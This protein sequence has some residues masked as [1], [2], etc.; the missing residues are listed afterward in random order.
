MNLNIEFQNGRWLVNNK[1]LAEMNQ[2]EKH[3][4]NGFFK[5]VKLKNMN[6]ENY[7]LHYEKQKA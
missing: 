7:L 4:M 1:T 6:L 5:E 3:F 2:Q